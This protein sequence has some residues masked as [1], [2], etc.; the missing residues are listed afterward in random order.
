MWLKLE[1]KYLSEPSTEEVA[2]WLQQ[3]LGFEIGETLSKLALRLMKGN[4][5]EFEEFAESVIEYLMRTRKPKPKKAPKHKQPAKLTQTPD[6]RAH[7]RD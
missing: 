6:S 4:R 1:I 3:V 5:A 7:T 2:L